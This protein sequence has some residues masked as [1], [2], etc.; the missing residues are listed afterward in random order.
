MLLVGIKV[1]E[2]ALDLGIVMAVVSSFKNRAINSKTVVFGEVGLAGE[3][4]SV[5]MAENRIAEVEKL[6]FERCILPVSLLEL[7]KNKPNIELV[8]VSNVAD[9]ISLI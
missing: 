3:I 6:G 5:S 2:P 4:R 8:G 9:A 7:I 1:N